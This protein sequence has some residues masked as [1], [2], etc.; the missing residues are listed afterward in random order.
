M[1][2]IKT[3]LG[4]LFAAQ[5]IVAGGLYVTKNKSSDFDEAQPLVKIA[6]EALTNVSISSIG[7]NGEET[8]IVLSK[9][10]DEW[11][12]PSLQNLPAN[13]KKIEEV[14]GKLN[15]IT[16]S[17][18]VAS[19]SGSR[20]RFEVDDE[21]YQRKIS[22]SSDGNTQVLF[23]GTSPGYR[24]IHARQDGES[25]IYSVNLA[26]HDFPTDALEW[27]DKG[28][29]QTNNL[30]LIKGADYEIVQQADVWNFSGPEHAGEASL[31][32]T[33]AEDLASVFSNIRIKDLAQESELKN[34]LQV[35]VKSG[36]MSYTYQFSE[37]DG[38]YYAKRSDLAPVFVIRDVDYEK[39]TSFNKEELAARS[40]E[41][42]EPESMPQAAIPQALAPEPLAPQADTK[43]NKTRP[44]KNEAAVDVSQK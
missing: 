29:L 15:T 32:P 14:L 9:V 7:E 37:S 11:Q 24:S 34:A 35:V 13:K 22:I 8:A 27:L 4:V 2:N 40:D 23:L 18:P 21:K 44:D 30:S 26:T 41:E 12:L 42:G 43:N 19:S 10:G 6:G 28:L 3:I 25:D 5:I 39:I 1:N 36:E 33:K 38:N 17:W 20:A 16:V 31:N